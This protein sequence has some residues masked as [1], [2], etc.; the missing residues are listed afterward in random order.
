MIMSTNRDTRI[1]F[2]G[3]MPY[4]RKTF[5]KINEDF[6][7]EIKYF[8]GNVHRDNLVLAKG[9]KVVCVFVN[10]NVDAEAIREFK[11]MGV[12]LIALRC[13]GFNNVDLEAARAEGIRVV[14]VPAYSP[15][16]VAEYALA[17]MLSL[18]RKIQRASW[19]TRDGN[20]SLN[21]L[22]GFDMHGKTV[23]IIGTGKIAKVLIGIL[24]GFG[25]NIL[26]Y[27]VYPD[28]AF[29]EANGVKY[30]SLDELYAGS[31]IISLH[32]PL[33]PETEYIINKE[34][35][36]KMKPGVMIINT[37]RGLLINSED[38]IEG[39][40]SRHV[41]FAGLDV[42]E[43]EANYFFKDKSDR[44]IEDDTLARL[45]SF[46]NVIMTSHQAFFTA[47]A[48]DNIAKTTFGNIEAYLSGADLENEVK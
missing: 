24:R 34:S 10:D 20:F 38:L 5:D 47:E 32:C 41:G 27:D 1:A 45:L 16:A 37:G 12:E 44:I 11:A 36:A 14:R 33:T 39:L 23:G 35:I 6:G 8:T 42:Y 28:H 48:T 2:Y 4:D 29:A 7:F 46:N 9:C 30:V 18:N 31:D 25:M 17:L 40:K 15:Y 26:A 21:G 19:R 3:T 13:A 43:E 22:L